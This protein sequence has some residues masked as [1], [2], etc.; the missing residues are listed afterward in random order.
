FVTKS[1]TTEGLEEA[2]ERL[3]SFTTNH[4]RRLLVVEDDPAEQLSVRELLGHTDVE[5]ICVGT[6][7]E[8]LVAMR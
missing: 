3:K 8:A 5:I 1:V 7:A 2:L 6:G 4:V